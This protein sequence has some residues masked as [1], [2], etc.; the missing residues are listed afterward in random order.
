MSFMSFS[1]WQKVKKEKK[2]KIFEFHEYF[3]CLLRGMCA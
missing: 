3:G 1:I 2:K